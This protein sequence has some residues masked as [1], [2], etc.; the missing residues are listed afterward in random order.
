MKSRMITL[1]PNEGG[2]ELF[3]FLTNELDEY[4]ELL[5]RVPGEFAIDPLSLAKLGANDLTKIMVGIAKVTVGAIV[6]G[7]LFVYM[8]NKNERLFF[9]TIADILKFS[10]DEKIKL[11]APKLAHLL[12]YEL[13]GKFD[14]DYRR[15]I[16]C[17]STHLAFYGFPDI[18]PDEMKDGFVSTMGIIGYNKSIK[19]DMGHTA[20][21]AILAKYDNYKDGYADI[22][23]K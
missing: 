3:D 1:R 4:K 2:E 6:S 12:M 5:V 13:F 18:V 22:E 7:D 17:D 21:M 16:K 8:S 9:D 19:T 20:A 23:R 14:Y 11:N 15:F 10:T